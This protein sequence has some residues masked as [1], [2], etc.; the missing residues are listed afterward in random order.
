MIMKKLL[1]LPFTFLFILCLQAQEEQHT[2]TVIGVKGVVIN[3]SGGKEL[4]AGDA[5]SGSGQEFTFKGENDMAGL[6]RNDGKRFVLLNR[7]EKKDFT[8]N[9]EKALMIGK[10]RFEWKNLTIKTLDELKLHLSE[11]PFVFLD[12]VAKIKIDQKTFPQNPR[13]FFYFNFLWK[14]PKGKTERVDKKLNSKRDTLIMRRSNIFRVDNTPVDPK[15]VSDFKLMYMN[16]GDPVE[17]GPFRVEFPDDEK[18]KNEIGLLVRQ[19]QKSGFDARMIQGEVEAFIRQFYGSIDR[20][21]LIN[22]LKNNFG[23]PEK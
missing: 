2:Y 11:A 1:L 5:I 12:T 9:M 3:K 23:I 7:K 6:V 22:Y 4:Q 18:M 8:C 15:D 17:I 10:T 16:A 20:L 14:N 19:Q 21:N 13:S